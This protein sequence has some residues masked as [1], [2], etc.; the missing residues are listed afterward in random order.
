MEIQVVQQQLRAAGHPDHQYTTDDIVY[1]LAHGLQYLQSVSADLCQLFASWQD[2]IQAVHDK[3]HLTYFL[4]THQLVA[5]SEMLQALLANGMSA[6]VL[7][8]SIAMY[9]LQTL[10]EMPPHCHHGS[11]T[12][13]CI[14][15]LQ[16]A[17]MLFT[18][19][20]DFTGQLSTYQVTFKVVV[21]SGYFR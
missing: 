10:A 1:E 9:M 20:V 3:H 16:L 17:N 15:C 19:S 6:N 7:R 2:Q 18:S 8:W 21:A 14:P 12:Q 4:S 11:S 13:L 5:A